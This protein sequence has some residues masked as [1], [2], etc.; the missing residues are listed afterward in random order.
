MIGTAAARQSEPRYVRRERELACYWR[1]NV[2]ART[3]CR[4]LAIRP[5]S[6]AELADHLDEPRS[7]IDQHIRQL[8]RFG[9]LEPAGLDRHGAVLWQRD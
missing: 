2:L 1:K 9:L 5:G 3:I 7:T 4:L 8:R 6:V